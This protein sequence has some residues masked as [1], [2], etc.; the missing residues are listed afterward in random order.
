MIF[1]LLI[2]FVFYLQIKEPNPNSEQMQNLVYTF[3]N[4]NNHQIIF[5]GS[6]RVLRQVNPLIIDSLTD[7]SSYCLGIDQI[8]MIESKML[9]MSYL[10]HHPKPKFVVLNIDLSTFMFNTNSSGPYNLEEYFSYTSDTLINNQL[11]RF[12]YKFKYPL[13]FKTIAATKPF[14]RKF[15]L[16]DSQKRS[17]F[18]S[19][20]IEIQPY[21]ESNLMKGFLATSQTW[22]DEAEKEY[23]KLNQTIL[24]EIPITEEGF[25]LLTEFIQVCKT[26][27]I[28][29]KLVFVPWYKGLKKNPNHFTV[30]NKVKT[31]AK[32][33]DTEFYDFSDSG[34]GNSKDLFYD[35]WHF[36]QKGSNL[37]SKLLAERIN[38]SRN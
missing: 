2:A 4:H 11:S 17:L 38:K 25:E 36:N 37:Y 23:N 7:L 22:N 26:R 29:C 13:I 28:E 33:S 24:E 18:F 16:S 3:N 6:S 19:K 32:D 14:I 5:I 10:A 15:T 30:L 31:I 8:G 21:T 20:N 9:L 12:N 35:C 27:K 1:S 34:L